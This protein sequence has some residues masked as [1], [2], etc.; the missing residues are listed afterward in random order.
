MPT[1]QQSSSR[2][3][4]LQHHLMIPQDHGSWV[5]LLSPLLIGLFAG[6]QW[7][8]AT[9]LLILASLAA[10][11]LRQPLTMVVKVLSRRRPRRI[12]PTALFWS[13]VYSLVAILCLTALVWMG[14]AYLLYLAIPG[15]PVFIW[16]LYL[17]SR[18]EE[19]GQPGLEVVASGVLALSAP[20]AL[21]VARNTPDPQGWVLWLLIWLQSAASIVHAHMRLKQR[22]L[23]EPPDLHMRWSLAWRA[24]TY[25]TFNLSLVLFFSLHGDLSRWLWTPYALQWLETIYGALKPAVRAKPTSIGFRQLAVSTLFTLLFIFIW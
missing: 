8:A 17:V 24:L 9:G 25:T 22:R 4:F 13:G 1:S 2:Q 10:F 23:I 12:L 18:R 3:T 6:G 14:H 16:H 11:F 15:I 19:R 21:W 7:T 5:F 20:A